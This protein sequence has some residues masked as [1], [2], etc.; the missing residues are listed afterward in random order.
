MEPPIYLDCHATTPLD[1]RVLD[2]MLPYFQ[3]HFGNAASHS[4]VFGLQAK[5]AVDRA[6][7]LVAKLI[8]A[9]PSEIVFTSGATEAL[10]LGLK[11]VFEAARRKGDHIVTVAT[12]HKAVLDTCLELEGRGARITRLGVDALGHVD[13]EALADAIDDDTILV[14]VMAANNEIGTLAPLADIGQI[15][16]RAGVLLL[17]DAAQAFGKIP[18]NV[19]ALG[20]DLLAISSHKIYGPKGVGA[21]YVRGHDPKVRLSAQMHGGGHERG[22]RSG[23]LDVPGIV[24]LGE[25]ARIAAEE[26]ASDTERIGSLRDRL[27]SRLLALPR[28]QRRGD[29]AARLAGNS[30]VTFS[31]VPS[32]TLMMQVRDVAVSS[33]SACTSADPSP[34]H[35]IQ[36]LGASKEE[37]DWTI[38][39]GLGRFTTEAEIDR[40]GELFEAAIGAIRGASPRW[41][42]ANRGGVDAGS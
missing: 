32:S 9:D 8:G 7:G 25:A 20:I 10:N 36:A 29:L 28:T 37:A 17:T 42:V 18:L 27:E 2:A 40:A 23:T 31:Y 11:G 6:R 34:S 21:L 41:E 4:H 16:R 30:S 33:G 24:G 39:F 22:M 14:A 5:A 26:M 19:E 13:L 38:R 3:E 15:T 35:V 1:P 12:E